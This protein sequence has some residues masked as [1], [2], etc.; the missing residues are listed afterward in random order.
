MDVIAHHHLKWSY[1]DAEGQMTHVFS[2]LKNIV[3]KQIQQYYEKQ[4]T[5]R[6]SHIQDKRGK[7]KEGS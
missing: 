2:H 7:V 5:L 1:P 6:G 3:L 4:V